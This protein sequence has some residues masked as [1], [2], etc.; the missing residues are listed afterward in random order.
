MTSNILFASVL[1]ILI[2][3]QATMLLVASASPSSLSALWDVTWNSGFFLTFQWWTVEGWQEVFVNRVDWE[4]AS[5]WAQWGIIGFTFWMCFVLIK[6][7]MGVYLVSYAT[8]RRAGMEAREAEDV[9]NDFGRDPIGEG[10][11]ERKYN[12]ELKDILNNTHDDT[13]PV[14]EIGERGSDEMGGR[15][16]DGK[17]KRP[18]L[19]ELTRFTMVKRIW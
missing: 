3:T 11:E 6:V 18:K 1:T 7:I 5:R 12:R 9:V 15:D 13:A 2:V 19:D 10:R 17:R 8:R 14:S 4:L 16:E